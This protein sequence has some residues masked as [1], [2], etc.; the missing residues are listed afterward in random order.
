[1]VVGACGRGGFLSHDSQDAK[2]QRKRV[3]RQD[4]HFKVTP[5]SDL[6]PSTRPYLLI[7]LSVMNTSKDQSIDEVSNLII[8]LCFNSAP[9]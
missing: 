5:L 1:M 7:S 4:I 9:S 3:V 2:R 8:Q 6:L